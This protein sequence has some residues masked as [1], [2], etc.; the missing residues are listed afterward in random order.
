MIGAATR[1]PSNGEVMDAFGH[2]DAVSCEEVADFH[3]HRDTSCGLWRK[4]VPNAKLAAGEPAE[5]S[6]RE[7]TYGRKPETIHREEAL[8]QCWT[9][10]DRD[11]R[12]VGRRLGRPEPEPE[13]ARPRRDCVRQCAHQEREHRAGWTHLTDGRR[14]LPRGGR[15]AVWTPELSTPEQVALRRDQRPAD[16]AVEE[17]HGQPNEEI[18]R[19]GYKA[20][21]EGDMDTLRSL[22]APD[23]V[24]VAT[25]NN[26]L[27]GEYKGVDDDPRLLRQALRAERRHLH[28]GAAEHE[29]RGRRHGRRDS[30]RQG[31]ARRARPS[32]RTRRSPSRSRMAS[33]RG[34]SRSTRTRRPTTPS[35]PSPRREHA[36]FRRGAQIARSGS[37]LV[38]LL[39]TQRSLETSSC[40]QWTVTVSVSRPDRS[41][42]PGRAPV[43]SPS[44]TVSIAVDVHA[45][46]AGRCRDHARRAAGQVAHERGRCRCRPSSGSNTT[47]SAC[48]PS[49][50]VPRSRRPNSCGR[51]S[52][53]W[54][55]P[56]TRA[57]RAVGRAACRRGTAW[58]T[59]CRTCGRGARRRRCRR[60]TRR[61]R[62]RARAAAPSGRRR[63]RGRSATAPCAGRRR[64]RC[65]PACRTGPRRLARRRCRARRDRSARRSSSLKV[66]PMT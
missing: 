47:R 63:R 30:P 32:T 12:A 61:G 26:P 13:C 21:G 64:S 34:S 17:S 22:Y 50:S 56:P 2:H 11:A 14:T 45:H 35:G 52:R 8:R 1:L 28:G 18:V 48:A 51:L 9:V 19:Q 27:S 23:A 31:P 4:L 25:G 58:G 44:T 49:A 3:A 53:S 38:G 41:T 66:S 60:G 40:R 55:A 7:A 20:F 5:S 36:E 29:G 10:L 39:G 37:L 24:H 33:S 59:S 6:S 42:V 16:A 57:R 54:R 15:R 43:A 65:R 46:H 62:P